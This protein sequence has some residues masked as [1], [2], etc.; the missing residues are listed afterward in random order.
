MLGT[1]VEDAVTGATFTVLERVQTYMAQGMSSREAEQQAMDDVRV[2]SRGKSQG[3][4]ARLYRFLKGFSGWSTGA[5]AANIGGA[6]F[7]TPRMD[8]KYDPADKWRAAKMFARQIGENMAKSPMAGEAGIQ[9]I[10][11]ALELVVERTRLIEQ[12]ASK[13]EMEANA[14]AI[15]N[16]GVNSQQLR[17]HLENIESGIPQYQESIGTRLTAK[18]KKEFGSNRAVVDALRDVMR[19]MGRLD[20][21]YETVPGAAQGRAYFASLG[22][23]WQGMDAERALED[24]DIIYEILRDVPDEI[25]EKYLQ[26]LDRHVT[27]LGE[28]TALRQ[29]LG[30]D[31]RDM[32]SDLRFTGVGE[33]RGR[34]RAGDAALKEARQAFGQYGGDVDRALAEFLR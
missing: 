32:E 31:L 28:A 2:A 9:R 19:I 23:A 3:A 29:S 21:A 33:Q 20:Y 15:K 8:L 12:G 30:E 4:K 7:G 34:L 5:G 6:L 14:A 13:Q 24:P 17:F 25:R 27:R 16:T 22:D 1:P 11:E 10:G 26:G 18:E